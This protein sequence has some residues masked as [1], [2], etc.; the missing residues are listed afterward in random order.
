[1]MANVLPPLNMSRSSSSSLVPLD[2][3]ALPTFAESSFSPSCSGFLLSPLCGASALR[4]P[5]F[6]DPFLN[7][8]SCNTNPFPLSPLP[9]A[10][11]PSQSHDWSPVLASPEL[12]PSAFDS[13]D[14]TT[15][16]STLVNTP[17]VPQEQQQTQKRQQHQQ[18]HHQ[19]QQARPQPVIQASLLPSP[20]ETEQPLSPP[21][22]KQQPKLTP[23]S[24]IDKAAERRRKNRESSSRCYYNRKR[25]IQTLEKELLEEKR[26]LTMLY[27]NAL[28]LRHDNARLKKEVVT[29][30]YAI[31]A[32][33]NKNASASFSMRDYL[34]LLHHS[35]YH[36]S[37]S[38]SQ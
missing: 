38:L 33:P 23:S 7:S 3:S 29:K 16:L 28:Q 2:F 12:Q 35:T 24:S 21:Q 18:H 14:S 10:Q 17:S 5:L 15:S 6:T 20:T 37:H 32:A 1:M 4:S 22:P 34:E 27:D 19:E 8:P 36:S 30:G 13:N 11:P 31:P 9:S 26:K 25:I